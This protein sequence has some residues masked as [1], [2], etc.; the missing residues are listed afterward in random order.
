VFSIA[1]LLQSAVYLI[2]PPFEDTFMESSS[3]A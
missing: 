2:P 1:A 3:Y